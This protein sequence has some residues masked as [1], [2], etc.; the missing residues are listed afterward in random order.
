M[1][2][3]GYIVFRLDNRGEGDRSAAFKQALY[4]KM[5]QPEIEDQVL[6]AEYLRSLPFVDDNR[7]AMMGWSY[8]GFMTLMAATEPRMGLAGA[9]AGAPPTEWGLYDTAYTE[10]YM[11]TPEANRE[12]YAASDVIPRLPNLTG[13]L[14]LMHGMADDNVILENSTRVINALQQNSQPFELML[15]PGQR[16]GV[17]GN[18][19]QL[20]QWRTYLDFLDRTIGT[21]SHTA[22]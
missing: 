21:R 14:L 9:L 13:R 17:R 6:A 15:Y 18:E 11:S 1:T 12:G 5:G 7:I 4:L 16:H 10:R 2:E 20:Q 19:R 8:G 3:A 22:E